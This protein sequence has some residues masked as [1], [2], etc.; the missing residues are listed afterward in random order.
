MPLI[1]HGP[2]VS[3]YSLVPI[4]GP[5][6]PTILSIAMPVPLPSPAGLLSM[7]QAMMIVMAEKKPAAA[8]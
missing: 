6:W 7:V 3:G 8:G 2:S 4:R 5:H 1:Y